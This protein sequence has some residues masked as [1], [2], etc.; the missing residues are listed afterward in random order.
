V[1]KQIYNFV[2]DVTE[3]SDLSIEQSLRLLILLFIF[4]P[5][6]PSTSPARYFTFEPPSASVTDSLL[7]EL[8]SIGRSILVREDSGE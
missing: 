4:I 6:L 7:R 3:S 2:M 1:V 8:A 5:L